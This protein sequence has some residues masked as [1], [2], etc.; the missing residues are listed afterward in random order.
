MTPVPLDSAGE[1][2]LVVVVVVV[3]ELQL[4][5]LLQLAGV[6]PCVTSQVKE[7]KKINFLHSRIIFARLIFN[8]LI[9][10]N[11]SNIKSR[12]R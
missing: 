3:V 9:L 12:R 5:E 8:H 1:L 7:Q 10:T 6:A 2:S 4:L 11:I